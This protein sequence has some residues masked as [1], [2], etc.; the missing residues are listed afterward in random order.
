M[1]A[2]IYALLLVAA[3]S[4]LA[5]LGI[6]PFLIDIR[7][8]F[9]HVSILSLLILLCLLGLLFRMLHMQRKGEKETLQRR[10]NELEKQFKVSQSREE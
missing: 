7:V 8:P 1:I 3:F 10:I 5:D 2:W 4:Y 6:L 9:L